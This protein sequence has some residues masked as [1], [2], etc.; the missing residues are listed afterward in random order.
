MKLKKVIQTKIQSELLKS[1]KK[2][3]QDKKVNLHIHEQVLKVGERV[4]MASLEVPI[5]Q[6]TALAFVDLA[7][8]YNWVHPCEYHLYDSNTGELYETINASVPPQKVILSGSN[9]PRY[10]LLDLVGFHKPVSLRDTASRRVGWDSSS[11]RVNSPLSAA[12]GER[13]AILFAGLA[14]NRHTNDLE[15]LYRTLI[16]DYGFRAA[17]IQVCNHDGSL[18]YFLSS[19]YGPLPQTIGANLG[20]WPG[21]NTPYR[22]VVNQPGTRNGLQ[23]AFNDIAGRIQPEDMLFI[24]T[25]NHG[26]GPCDPGINDYCAFE[27]DANVS[28]N[29]YYV[30]DFVTDLAVLPDIEVL[31]VMMEQCRSGGFINPILNNSPAKWTHMCTAVVADDYSLG[32]ANFDPF[33]EDWIAAMHGSYANGGGLSQVV[34]VNNNGRISAEEAFNYAN[35]VRDFNGG[36]LRT[37]PTPG[38]GTCQSCGGAGGHDLRL[39]D[40]PTSDESPAGC[41]ANIYLG[42]PAHDLYLR[43]NLQDHGQEPLVDG[44]ISC[45]PDIIVYRQELL[46]P[47]ATLGTPAAQNSDTLSEDVEIGQDNY[48]YLRVQNRGTQPTSGTARVF[49][50]LPSVLPTPNSWHEITDPANPEPIPAVT[51][52]EM[53][54]VG[55]ITW[56]QADIPAKGHYCFIGLI[57]SGDDPAPD[58][59]TIHTIDDYYNFIRANNN[60]T[61]KN[62]DTDN[63]FANSVANLKFA[64]QGWPR[65]E[66]SSDLE[67]DLTNLPEYMAAKL[68]IIKRLSSSSQTEN[69]TLDTE[70]LLYQKFNLVPGKQAFLRG[71]NL[72]P[73]DKCQAYLE[74]T[75]PDNAE[76]GNYRLSVAQLVDGR[77]MGRV[78]RMLAV[79]DH[80]FM[81]NHRSLEL[82]IPACEWAKKM[83]GRNKVAYGSIE[84]ALKHGYNGCRYCLPEYSTD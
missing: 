54:I 7:P 20:N 75:I 52:G 43:D 71:M 57:N 79:G 5:E 23:A 67:I 77:E 15:F 46:D 34:D 48:I 66:L 58:Q 17:N 64:I 60:A 10:E 42:L 69:A 25:N 70:S 80:P 73:S 6:D 35:A 65:V 3:K 37:C 8:E 82:H 78:S 72:K 36:V 11:F 45:S 21:N 53:A 49:W 33:A 27:Y 19:Q 41:G 81:G 4:K 40:T 61:W 38:V 63:V 16:D 51:P 74:I 26:G 50:A 18:N 29:P 47:D 2:L 32:G 12:P 56:E 55:P 83:S 13:Y 62:F 22:M 76:D 31:M 1:M 44:G 39:G 30:N 9:A 14:E 68:R 24:H 59:S 84:R 28:W